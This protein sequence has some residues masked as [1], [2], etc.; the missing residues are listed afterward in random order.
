M[1]LN[2]N[3]SLTAIC[4]GYYFV[5]QMII[6]SVNMRKFAM[7]NGIDTYEYD[8]SN[9]SQPMSVRSVE[10]II[11]QDISRNRRW[12][13]Y[14]VGIFSYQV[15]YSGNDQWNCTSKILEVRYESCISRLVLLITWNMMERICDSALVV[16]IVF[17]THVQGK[18]ISFSQSVD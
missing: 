2:C 16:V 1:N 17:S 3:G 8:L 11:T 10:W 12:F 15:R 18:R 9:P 6:C 14:F 4:N 13:H 7:T 5:L